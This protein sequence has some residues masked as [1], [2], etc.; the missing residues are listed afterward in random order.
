MQPNCQTFLRIIFKQK[1]LPKILFSYFRVL[2]ATFIEILMIRIESFVNKH[3]GEKKG[4]F[5]QVY[6]A[7]PGFS[8]KHNQ[9]NELKCLSVKTDELVHLYL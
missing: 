7:L 8:I 3:I 9:Q 4:H 6:A 2:T 1:I 5:R